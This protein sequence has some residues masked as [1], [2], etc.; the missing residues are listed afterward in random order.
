MYGT[1]SLQNKVKLPVVIWIHGGYLLVGFGHQRGYS[2][3]AESTKSMGV[4]FVSFNY[5]LNMF[6]FLALDALSNASKTKTSGN[7]GLMDQIAVL[8]WVQRNIENFGGDPKKV[9]LIGQ[10]SGGTSI[11]GLLASKGAQGLFKTV[12][13]M[14]GSPVYNKTANEAAKDNL[15]FL[16]NSRC[17]NTHFSK[18]CECLYKLS[19]EQILN[20]VPWFV[21]PNWAMAD[22]LD[23]PTKNLFDGAVC[24]VDGD[25]VSF[26]PGDLKLHPSWPKGEITI[27]LGTTAQEIDWYPLQDFRN[28]SYAEFEGFAQKRLGA[29]SSAIGNKALALYK[30]IDNQTDPQ[31]V[32]ETMATDVRVTCPSNI[33]ASN[34]SLSPMH[35]VYRYII[36]HTPSIPALLSTYPSQYASHMW[37]SVAL[38]G[39][40]G[41]PM[42]FK[43]NKS[44]LAFM[45]D[46]RKQF[47]HFFWHG[48]AESM[49]WKLY[50]EKIGIFSNTG[51]QIAD[52]YH[53]KQY[54]FWNKNGFFSYGWIN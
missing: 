40:D 10:S 19:K 54:D 13:P 52:D 30:N 42:H 34:F 20:A 2:P 50:P 18:V 36:T 27:L 16:N 33:L 9:T 17:N 5:R 38:F 32:Y 4:V 31:Y 23:L 28:K 7:Y 43:P 1:P 51:L 44:D 21:Y 39:F 22:L 45:N 15:I 24:T 48:H 26:P 14:S 12:I 8:K 35:K 46:L 11:Y 25:A 29:F 47:R 3:N 37:D 49:D 6:G 53:R 41:M